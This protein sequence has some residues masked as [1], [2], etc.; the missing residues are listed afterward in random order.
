MAGRGYEAKT[1]FDFQKE[2]DDT[3]SQVP[4]TELKGLAPEVVAILNGAGYRTLSDVLDLD[5]EDVAR[6]PGMTPA[7]TDHLMSF[8]AELTDEDGAEEARPTA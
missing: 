2:E 1:S 7:T 4:L 6:I 8:L 3:A 5:R